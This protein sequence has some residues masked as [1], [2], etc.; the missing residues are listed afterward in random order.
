MKHPSG[1]N[2]LVIGTMSGTSLDGLDIAAVEFS[3]L[4]SDWSF[5]LKA[6]ETVEYS[7]EWQNRLQ[8]APSLSGEQLI[9]LHI[10]F[11]RLTGAEINRFIKQHRLHPDLIASHGHTVF[12][13]PEKR[14]T[15]QSGDGYS[16]AIATNTITVAD[17]RNGDVALGGQGAPLVPAGDRLLFPEYDFCLNL[18]GFANISFEQNNQRIAYD[19]CPVNF[20]LNQ[21]AAEKGMPFDKNGELGKSGNV[22][23]ELLEKLNKLPF[24]FKQPPK[25]LGREWMERYFVP[26]VKS[27][28]RST[29]E[30][31]RTIYEHIAIQISKSLPDNGK[32]LVTGGGAFNSFLVERI[33]QHLKADVVL[34]APKII[35]FKEAIVFAFLGLLRYLNEINCYAS[36]TGAQKDSSAG[37]IF[38]P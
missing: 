22:H 38:H 33:K 36:V 12:H 23:S 25:S 27:E 28:R 16:I 7:G 30:K 19:I 3:R 8:N 21:L 17:F 20:I 31:L 29:E 4:N 35:S 14:F 9:A 15:F 2:Y 5:T 11:G 10:D 34:P 13:Q 26:I 37:V 32:M 6:A 18:G 24:Y 1:N